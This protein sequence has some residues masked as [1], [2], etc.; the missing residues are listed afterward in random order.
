M[1]P[2]ERIVRA[3][4][5]VRLGRCSLFIRG[6]SGSNKMMNVEK[7]TSTCA[8]RGCDDRHTP[9]SIVE[10]CGGVV[11]SSVAFFLAFCLRRFPF[12][13]GA[14]GA[15]CAS[16]NPRGGR[17]AATAA[18]LRCGWLRPR[19][20]G[21]LSTSY[22]PRRS[23]G[24][25]VPRRL[26]G[27]HQTD[28]KMS[29]PN[30][31]AE[32]SAGSQGEPPLRNLKDE[33][34][35]VHSSY[36]T[37]LSNL[38]DPLSSTRSPRRSGAAGA[39][40]GSPHN[41][42]AA[43]KAD[44]EQARV[45][46]NLKTQLLQKAHTSTSLQE[47]LSNQKVQEQNLRNRLV[48]EETSRKQ[49]ALDLD[50]AKA[51]VTTLRSKVAEKSKQ[52]VETLSRIHSLKLAQKRLENQLREKQYAEKRS[53]NQLETYKKR[54][55]K[56][57]RELVDLQFEQ[58]GKAQRIKEL[59]DGNA[60]LQSDLE[61]KTQQLIQETH[62]F[63]A[64]IKGLEGSI[65]RKTAELNSAQ[66]NLEAA[67]ASVKELTE[68]AWDN[69]QKAE[70]EK[71]ELEAKVQE[72][73]ARLRVLDTRLEE[74]TARNQQ[75]AK[76][77]EAAE[78]R[79]DVLAKK[80]QASED[81]ER[82]LN[83]SIL[84]MQTQIQL[85][86]GR[87]A[88]VD[89]ENNALQEA[90]DTKRDELLVMEGK[91]ENTQAAFDDLAKSVRLSEAQKD[92]Y[93]RQIGEAKVALEEA[94][95]QVDSLQVLVKDLEAQVFDRTAVQNQLS[96][97][98]NS[99]ETRARMLEDQMLLSQQTERELNRIVEER[100]KENEKLDQQLKSVEAELIN[101]RRR[102]KLEAIELQNQIRQEQQ[103]VANVRVV[104]LLVC[105][106]HVFLLFFFLFFFVNNFVSLARRRDHVF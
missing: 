28:G 37:A 81:S 11:V 23:A 68:T 88:R 99:A 48:I 40:G 97:D 1:R 50:N 101:V 75:L 46:D 89:D 6:M 20:G 54:A 24:N 58:K 52:E 82:T 87:V 44:A 98:L 55:L 73:E 105:S 66:S 56:I 10:T 19:C 7:S 29:G 57:E 51:R 41:S 3:R 30:P 43:Y 32:V 104:R 18:S 95:A 49:L 71:N 79:C 72:G 39:S 102:H 33:L 78:A 36:V 15:T 65:A 9:R 35:H 84:A 22:S 74:A 16:A 83:G 27:K 45:V 85:L 14:P 42:L 4:G 76:A 100:S 67:E 96:A 13:R 26:Y 61:T 93:D 53:A 77:V 8:R 63:E 60:R 25:E 59:Q 90:L 21:P 64:Q 2:S 47:Q 31:G 17:A 12:S 92:K 103:T 70:R 34:D 91:L 69:M 86:E 94:Q 106:H 5:F 80:L 38:S 62:S